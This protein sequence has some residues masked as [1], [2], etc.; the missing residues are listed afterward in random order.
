[1]SKLLI[2]ESPGKIKKISEYLGDDYIV[3][4]SVGHIID[5]DESS[6]SI[7]L[8]TFEPEYK[9]YDNKKDVVSKLV[10][11]TFKVG[12]ENVLLAAD[13]DRE[14][15]MI[16][17]SL[18]RELKL[19]KPK[20]IVFNS[21]TAK[22]LK[23]AVSNP[24]QVDQNMVK[25]QQARR[26]L[27]RL[28]G[29][30][31]SPI[32]RKN[33]F[34]AAKS[35]GRVQSVVVK[36]V[37]D[38]ERE[39]EAFYK[40]KKSTYFYIC[41]DTKIGE[42]QIITKL[43]NKNTKIETIGS[44]ELVDGDNENEDTDDDEKDKKKKKTNKKVNT[45]NTVS[46]KSYLTFDKSEEDSVLKIIKAMMKA[47]YSLLK[48]TEK[49]RKSN[50]PPPFT[51]STLQQC[52]SQRLNMDAK[53][54]MSV[55]QKLYEGGHITYMRTD[56]TSISEEAIKYIKDV[57]EA[58][59]GIEHYESHTFVNK[60]ANTQEAHECVRPTKPQYDT[61]DGSPDEKR[62]YNMIWKRTIQSQMKAAE[63][64]S[65]LIEI[66]LEDKKKILADYKLVGTLENL[67]YSGYL[68]V[69]GKKDS[70]PLDTK[71]LS[72][73]D[74]V[75]INGIEDTQKP[76]TR[77]NDASLINKMDP[78]NLNIGRPSTYASFIEKIQQRSYVETK[79]IEGKKIQV[80]KY[81]AKKSDLKNIDLETKDLVLGKEKKKLVPTALGISVT[82][83]L[84]KNFKLL[85]DYQFTANM[86][87][88]LDDIAEG[89][90]NSVT[91]MKKFYDYVIKCLSDITPGPNALVGLNGLNGSQS[92][93]IVLGKF[94]TEEIKLMS[95]PYGKYIQC[96]LNKFNLKQ[97]ALDLQVVESEL[98]TNSKLL[99]DTVTEKLD[100]KVK[101]PDK[102]WKIGKFTYTLKSGRYGYYLEESSSTSK[103]SSN[104]SLN[105]L[106][107]NLAK[108]NEI[109]LENASSVSK[110]INLITD[111]HIQETVEYFKNAKTNKSD[112]KTDNKFVKKDT[113]KSDSNK[114]I[115]EDLEKELEATET[116][117]KTTGKKTNKS[118]KVKK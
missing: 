68:L 63:Y 9:I 114:D 105:Y 101:N 100:L 112:T 91:V 4:A 15:E 16:A 78:K 90:L 109:D 50:A 95:G 20:R 77:Y 74:W 31:I 18:A 79:D 27:D 89:T 116:I 88:E 57:I 21:I 37:V 67:I 64:Q 23:A 94:G 55:A 106:I 52:A 17:W 62:L 113:K 30:L 40:Q 1:M 92:N 59:Y 71:T 7:N 22:E 39:I 35:A 98:E 36:I 13:E 25:A 115:E 43:S 107:S 86:E 65:I 49:T 56:S 38:K 96:G 34:Y 24:K 99:L 8:E 60:K 82:E 73:I 14:G 6:M 83:F 12:K 3:S 45:S 47:E 42:Y 75:E 118:T 29:Y 69:D 10:K 117:K 80:N 48:K 58:E 102:T 85:M 103:K 81:T 32:L 72:P 2:V 61:I 54:T 97:I 41:S 104:Y 110:V 46:T 51:T 84:E 53:R 19:T 66:N 76:P 33:G 5:L 87:T 70:K 108:S 26:I 11:Q 44:D 111:Q 28:A 93:S